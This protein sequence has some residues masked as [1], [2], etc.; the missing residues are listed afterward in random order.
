MIIILTGR[1]KNTDFCNKQL[2]FDPYYLKK[3]PIVF[4]YFEANLMCGSGQLSNKDSWPIP[5]EVLMIIWTGFI[6]KS[7]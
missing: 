6:K 7:P 4:V 2:L 5:S 3:Q 1:I